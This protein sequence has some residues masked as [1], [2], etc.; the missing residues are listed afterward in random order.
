MRKK[1]VVNI[2]KLAFPDL[3]EPPT[4]DDRSVRFLI[5][6][7]AE[8]GKAG[9]SG[10]RWTLAYRLAGGFPVDQIRYPELGTEKE[11]ERKL[12]RAPFDPPDL[13]DP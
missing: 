8:A 9:K 12:H 6:T 10:L 11:G 7:V 3:P 4:R 13:Q 2:N 1:S 5:R